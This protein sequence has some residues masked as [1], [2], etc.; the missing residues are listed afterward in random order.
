MFKTGDVVVINHNPYGS[1][2]HL[3]NGLICIVETVL[4][5]YDLGTTEEYEFSY[6]ILGWT[7]ED[8]P[9][10]EVAFDINDY[11]WYDN[12]LKLFGPAAVYPPQGLP[13]V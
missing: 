3:L 13:N 2:K 10:R 5:S 9:G 4:D 8:N 12:D 1:S 7:K 6:Y 11:Y